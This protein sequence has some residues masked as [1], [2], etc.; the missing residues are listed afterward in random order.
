MLLYWLT[1]RYLEGRKLVG[2]L[3][4]AEGE[5]SDRSRARLQTVDGVLGAI[6]ADIA[7]AQAELGTAA[8]WFE[9][10]DDDEGRATALVGLGLATAPI[11]AD[12]ARELMRDGA[13]LFTELDDAWAEAI[14]LGVLGWLD[15]GRGDFTEEA[16][17]ERGYALARYVEDEVSTAHT[18]TDLAELHLALGRPDEARKVMEVALGA[19]EAVQLQDGLSYGLEPVARFALNG[20]RAG[21]AARLLGAAD[22]LRDGVGVPIWG[23]RRARFESLVATVREA[24]GDELFGMRWTEGRSLDYNGALA[25]ARGALMLESAEVS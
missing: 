18:A 22:G 21:D 7:T 24:L 6:L 15:V 12:R 1:G 3:L 9:A 16:L 23:P 14:A 11:D 10:H 5:L 13:R 20:G 17:F 25:A 2:R 19:Y 8:S 4:D